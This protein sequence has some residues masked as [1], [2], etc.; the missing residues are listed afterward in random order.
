MIEKATGLKP[1]ISSLSGV[2]ISTH[3]R[4]GNTTRIIDNAVQLLFQGHVVSVD[5]HYDGLSGRL[6]LWRNLMKRLNEHHWVVFETD[7][8]LIKIKS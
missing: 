4:A 5:D 7:G 6:S 3:R 8:F 2:E 1:T